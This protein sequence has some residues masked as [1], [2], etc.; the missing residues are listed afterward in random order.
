MTYTMT[1]HYL[2]FNM[3][4]L[5]IVKGNTF[6]TI[7][8]V[9]AYKYNGE[10]IT[11]FN[12]QDCTNVKVI[13]HNSTSTTKIKTFEL[14][15]NNKMSIHWSKSIPLGKHCLEVTGK[16]GDDDWRFYDKS[17]IFIIVN[18]NAEANI[19]KHSIIKEDCYSVDKQKLYIIA[20]KGDK[21]D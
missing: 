10:E 16:Y 5:K 1:Y 6:D 8:E 17:P 20:P 9:K 2:A 11:D 19:P 12:L 7:V 3:T 14:L 21:G 4:D 13:S 18:T 15:E